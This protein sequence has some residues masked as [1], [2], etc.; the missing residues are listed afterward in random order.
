MDLS[1]PEGAGKM[2]DLIGTKK[3]AEVGGLIVEGSE[4]ASFCC[5]FNARD[6]TYK[7][8]VYSRSWQAGLWDLYTLLNFSV[9]VYFPMFIPILAIKEIS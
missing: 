9:S 7:S 4:T 5:G 8:R 2:A 6:P 3:M 1:T